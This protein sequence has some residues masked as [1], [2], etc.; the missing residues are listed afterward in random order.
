MPFSHR[1]GDGKFET[2]GAAWSREGP[3]LGGRLLEPHVEEGDKGV[4]GVSFRR[5]LI[6]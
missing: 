5:A 6:S 2:R 3:L 1:S 4:S